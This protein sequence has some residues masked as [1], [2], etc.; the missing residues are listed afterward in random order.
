MALAP[1]FAGQKLASSSIQ[2]KAVHTLEIY[3]DYVCPFSAKLFK[4]VYQT[5]LK[6][7]LLNKYG[8]KVVTIFRQQIQPWYTPPGRNRLQRTIRG[9]G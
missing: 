9:V 5:P 8:D 6:D 3:L 4:T 7:T 1:K 2:P